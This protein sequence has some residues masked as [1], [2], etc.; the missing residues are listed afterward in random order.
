MHRI[1]NAAVNPMAD[2]RG[3]PLVESLVPPPDPVRCC[4]L[5][6]GLPYR[7]YLDAV[8]RV[9]DYILA[10]DVF[11]A[12]LPQRFDAPLVE[13]P[14]TLYCRLRARNAAPFA[15][16]LDFPNAAVLSASLE[17][18]LRVGEAETS[19]PP[20]QRHTPARVRSGARR[21]AWPGADQ[22]REG[23]GRE[24]HDRRSHAQRSVEGLRR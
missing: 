18:F 17:R 12:N 11:Q 22:E 15:A 13:L 24:P 10:G 8:A 5:L 23:S 7:L 6:H 4:E 3:S 20:Y 14:W 16:F 21:R 2:D 9:R 1:P 19:S